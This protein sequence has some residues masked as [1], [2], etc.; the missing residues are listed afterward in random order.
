MSAAFDA[1]ALAALH[2][3]CFSTPRPWS[4]AE[5]ADLNEDPTTHLILQPDGFL[6]GRVIADEAEILTL[7]VDPDRRRQGIARTLLHKFQEKAASLNA[8][9]VFLEVAADNLAAVQ[10]YTACGYQKTG[11]R[12]RYFRDGEGNFTDAFIL[13]RVLSQI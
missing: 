9:A 10:L 7:A 13:R 2:K 6:A 1:E 8:R 3:R 5:F 11:N 12:P 4:A